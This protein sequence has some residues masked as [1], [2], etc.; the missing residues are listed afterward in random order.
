MYEE[1]A[2]RDLFARYL[3]MLGI[4]SVRPSQRALSEL[5]T[6][7]VERVPFENISKLYYRKHD[8]LRRLPG[9]GLFLD[10]I[11][12][13]NFGGT[14][15][16]NNYY[17][18]LLLEHLGYQVDL[19][20]A[21][22]ANPDVHIVN[23]VTVDGREYLVDVGYAAPFLE[24]LPRDL[25]QDHVISLG[26]DRYVLKP[27]DAEGRSRVE[28]YRNHQ[29]KHAY[30]ARPVPRPI[31]YFDRVIADSFADD[32]TFMNALLLARF[33]RDGS[34]TVHNLA[35]VRSRGTD[36]HIEQLDSRL[37]LVSAIERHF[38]M[39]RSVVSEVVQDLGELQ[40]AWK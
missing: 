3:R 28:L 33:S 27:Q 25:S 7:H 12:Q 35:L 14:C 8:G 31:G 23:M 6:A 38:A 2:T 1:P 9:L 37:E 5:V 21:D 24:P 29:L 19:C 17:L 34:L 26:R 22:M 15:Y 16:A 4:G 20:G 13:H 11:E 40:D 36:S 32:A 39:P 10:G 30:V 18:H